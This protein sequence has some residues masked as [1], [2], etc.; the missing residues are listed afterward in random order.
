MNFGVLGGG[1]VGLT[2]ALELQSQFR[3][4]KVT[5]VADK[6][7][8]E[9]TSAVAAGIFRPAA[10]FAGPTDEIT[11]Q[12]IDDAFA[13]WDELRKRE[14]SAKVG[15][16]NLSGYIFSSTNPAIVRNS[17]IE[18][19]LPLYRRATE[20]ELKMCPGDWK[21]GSFF[22]TLL[23]EFRTFQPWAEKKFLGN[24][25]K[26]V[27]RH[28]SKLTDLEK[29]FNLVFNCTGLGSKW[30]LG[31]NK[32]VPIRGQIIKVKAP[33]VKTAFY[34]DYD[35]YIIPGFEGVTLGGTRQFDSYNL[36]ICKY[37]TASIRERC[38]DLLPSLRG[39]PVIRE[40]VGLRP[41]RDPVRVEVEFFPTSHGK[42]MSVIHNYGH[43]GSGVTTSP[44]TAKY[45]VKLVR[46]AL[47][48]RSHL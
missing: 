16:C 38:Q 3:D 6:W 12:W 43:G 45:A 26:Y 47:G 41:H 27:T 34:G 20:D 19:L 23:T 32:L 39:A 29:D 8:T 18:K 1:V 13:H 24:G 14:G 10:S 2:T 40:S 5:I 35:T 7:A 48:G 33:W 25:G 4:A 17:R 22:S 9:T 28:V 15:I 37:D 36:N 30:M 46:D 11:Q 21:Y 44:G 31:D 42:P